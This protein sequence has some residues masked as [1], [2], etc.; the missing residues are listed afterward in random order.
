VA[1]GSRVEDNVVV[2]LVLIRQQRGKVVKRNLIQVGSGIGADQQ[3]PF[4]AIG[5]IQRDSRGERCFAHP[6]L[7]CEEQMPC[8]MVQ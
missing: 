5:Q 6:T 1:R 2:P 7:A 3:D 4:S 8:W